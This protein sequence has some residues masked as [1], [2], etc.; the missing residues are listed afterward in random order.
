MESGYGSCVVSKVCQNAIMLHFASLWS[1]DTGMPGARS[2]GSRGEGS[3]G[4]GIFSGGKK[5]SS[6]Q[7]SSVGHHLVAGKSVH[8]VERAGGSAQ[9]PVVQSR[10]AGFRLGSRLLLLPGAKPCGAGGLCRPAAQARCRSGRSHVCNPGSSD[11]R[12]AV[13]QAWSQEG[14]CAFRSFARSCEGC[15]RGVG[16][17]SRRCVSRRGDVLHLGSVL[18]WQ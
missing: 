7:V 16:H 10:C 9:A 6:I 15:S 8:V 3:F 13:G 11:T 17:R 2:R 1:S 4:W 18:R 14:H 5:V 12:N